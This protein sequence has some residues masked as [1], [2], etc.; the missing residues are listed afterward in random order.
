MAS[1]MYIVITGVSVVL[2]AVSIVVVWR[3]KALPFQYDVSSQADPPDDLPETE[4]QRQEYAD[5]LA[6]LHRNLR[7]ALLLALVALTVFF[8]ANHKTT[9]PFVANLCRLVS[10]SWPTVVQMVSGVVILYA[11]ALCFRQGSISAAEV[12]SLEDK[13]RY[14]GLSRSAPVIF[15]GRLSP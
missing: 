11:A 1:Y 4:E 8:L 2:A 14:R 3:A 6:L 10:T 7:R 13:R 12:R 9:F 5:A 15:P